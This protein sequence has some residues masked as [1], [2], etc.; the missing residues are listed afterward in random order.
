M[1]RRHLTWDS[2]FFGVRVGMCALSAADLED[3]EHCQ[4]QLRD[5]GKGLQ[6]L[7][8]DS[9]EVGARLA[10]LLPDA[11]RDERLLFAKQL[12]PLSPMALP[13]S[14]GYV[15][16][17]SGALHAL[18]YASGHCSR[19]FRDA[20]LR[21]HFWGLYDRWLLRALENPA[22]VVWGLYMQG[23]LVAMLTAHCQEDIVRIGL[24]AV[25]EAYRGQG[26]GRLLMASFE[27]EAFRLWGCRQLQVLTQGQNTYA[28]RFYADMGYAVQQRQYMFHYWT[29]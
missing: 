24:L 17:A 18:A 1:K 22:E 19:F 7:Q 10:A 9:A 26:L 28:C 2:D 6:Y 4:A 13:P 23:E 29:E 8:T 25:A 12:Q 3:W 15:R 27:Q 11:C 16:E 21:P 14:V 5:W 20:R